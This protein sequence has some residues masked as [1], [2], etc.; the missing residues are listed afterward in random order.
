MSKK[1]EG[2]VHRL[3]IGVNVAF[4]NCKENLEISLIL[5]YYTFYY[6]IGLNY[7]RLI[8][9]TIAIIF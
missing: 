5:R 4:T 8:S 2:K 7:K 9:I 3:P 1:L 6:N